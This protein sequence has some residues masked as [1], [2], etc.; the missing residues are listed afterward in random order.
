MLETCVFNVADTRSVWWGA[1]PV[2]FRAI[3][4]SSLSGFLEKEAFLL[5][6]GLRSCFLTAPRVEGRSV[7]MEDS[8][9][10]SHWV[11]PSL[12]SS[13]ALASFSSEPSLL[14]PGEASEAF[15]SGQDSDLTGLA[16]FFP[17]PNHSRAPPAYR[18][19]SGRCSRSALVNAQ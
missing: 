8:P 5:V 1:A 19:S 3:Y 14:P 12:L 17:S 15:F 11:S 6:A 16:S 13:D 18:H 2:P 10:H 4:F 9:E 7:G